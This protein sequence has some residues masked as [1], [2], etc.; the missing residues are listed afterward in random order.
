LGFTLK[1][2]IF[3]T[4]FDIKKKNFI[5]IQ[6]NKLTFL[7]K[8]HFVSKKEI[9]ILGNGFYNKNII[10]WQNYRK[11]IKNI[12]NDNKQFIINF[13]FHPIESAEYKL[14]KF[15]DKNEVL[16][17]VN[18]LPI[19]IKIFIMKKIPFKIYNIYST[20]AISLSKI[21]DNKIKIININIPNKLIKS[22]DQ[23]IKVKL[24]ENYLISNKTISSI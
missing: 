15:L 14:K 11:I 18:T 9:I 7:C 21:L 12:I 5:S 6:E 16:Y 23:R 10:S 17:S 19:E 13:H 1:S 3:F 22:C 2:V 4:L 8:H 20:S 24:I